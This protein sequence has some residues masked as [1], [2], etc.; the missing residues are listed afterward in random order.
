MAPY[1][2]SSNTGLQIKMKTILKLAFIVWI[3]LWMIFFIR[4]LF[5]KNNFKDYKILLSRTLE[6]KQSYVTVD[7]FYELLSLCKK[8]MPEGSTYAFRVLEGNFDWSIYKTR[9]AY[10]LYPD[11]E[12]DDPQFIIVYNEPNVMKEGYRIYGKL[13][14]NRYLLNKSGSR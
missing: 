1:G 11:I 13:D 8:N 2:R 14:D 9:A 3:A 12:S 6:G 4:E 7:K 10:Y 5:L